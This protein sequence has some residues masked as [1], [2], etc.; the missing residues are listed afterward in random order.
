MS[1]WWG[2]CV[3]FPRH[4]LIS[5]ITSNCRLLHELEGW[6]MFVHSDPSPDTPKSLILT[7]RNEHYI[8]AHDSFQVE[9]SGSMVSLPTAWAC[10]SPTH[11]TH[12]CTSLSPTQAHPVGEAG[13]EVRKACSL[14]QEKTF[15]STYPM[16][17]NIMSVPSRPH[18]GAG[19]P[20]LCTAVYLF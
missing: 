9:G 20:P 2:Y 8:N 7:S 11:F 10:R 3:L 16:F 1:G 4:S 6:D 17:P 13:H 15:N 18:S 14:L 19:I 5:G 12:T